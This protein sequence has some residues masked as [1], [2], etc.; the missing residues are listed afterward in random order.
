MIETTSFEQAGHGSIA[1][2]R[3]V[4]GDRP[5]LA[6]VNAAMDELQRSLGF[7]DSHFFCECGGIL[8]KQRVTLTRAEYASLRSAS[9]LVISES[10]AARL[11][12]YLGTP[13]F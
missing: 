9:K 10:H 6:Y 8:C 1:R 12:R 3:G 4:W 11:L 5:L 13:V 2:E 7:T